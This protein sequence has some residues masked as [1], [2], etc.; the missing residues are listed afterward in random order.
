MEEK[1][2]IKTWNSLYFD[3]AYLDYVEKIIE[4]PTNS[5]LLKSF[6]KILS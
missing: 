6:D 4:E 5:E 2:N 1:D 3:S